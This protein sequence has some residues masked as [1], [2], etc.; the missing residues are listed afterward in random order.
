MDCTFALVKKDEKGD[1]PKITKDSWKKAKRILR[2][3]K[4]YRVLYSTSLIV[5]LIGSAVSMAFPFLTGQL[6]GTTSTGAGFDPSNLSDTNTVVILLFM[7]FA[8][9]SIFSFFRIYLTSIVTENV[10][11]DI[12]RESYRKLITLPISFYNKNKTGELTSRISADI[13]VLQETFNTIFPEF[14][15]QFIVIIVGMSFLA[16]LSLKLALIMLA[17]IPV[18]ALVAVFFGR[19]IKKISKQAQDKVA[20]SNSIVEETLTAITSVKAFANEY[21]EIIRYKNV[22]EDVKKLGLRGALWRGFF[23]SFII[24]CMFGSI[25]FVIW[26]G[27]I[28]KNAGL[29]TLGEFMSFIMFS[30][31]IGASFG[32]IPELYAKIQNAIGAT[33][34]L[35]DILE[36]QSEDVEVVSPVKSGKRLLGSVEFSNVNF[37]YES[38]PDIEVLKNI[39]FKVEPGMQV[40]IVGPSGSGKSTLASLLF[41]FYNPVSGFINYDGNDIQT[42][43]LSEMRGQMALVPQ[44]VILYSGSIEEN[45]SYGK[46]NAS[47][48]EIKEAA[49][50]ANALEFIE[51]FPD[52]FNTIVGERGIQLSGGQRQRIAI[53]RAVLKDP[54]I[55]IL[56]EATSSLDSESERLVQEALEKLMQGRTSFVIA[57][58][59]STIKNADIILVIEN[60]ILV[61]AGK[62]DQLVQNEKGLYKKLSSLQYMPEGA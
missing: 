3:L 55:L 16:F 23:V 26:Q 43:G 13:T 37:H 28:M 38:R 62:H 50:K 44:E 24:F 39:S 51:R 61:E 4:P 1:K 36:E 32:S 12:R 27:V 9:Q 31:F 48:D 22:T 7:V 8:L 2:Y 41:R 35:M 53:A 5:L 52:K 14:I 33:E 49:R 45:I 42:L 59:L 57:H 25:I 60:G 10:L 46:P 6:F 58:R 56:D 21:L 17:T 11:T 40:A 54:S 47:K 34:R 19:F 29:L 30:I 20:E 18:M 15:R